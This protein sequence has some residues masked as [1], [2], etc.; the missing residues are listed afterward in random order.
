MCGV[1]Y[2]IAV[3]NAE[4]RGLRF[5]D[6]NNTSMEDGDVA[7]SASGSCHVCSEMVGRGARIDVGEI[8]CR[9]REEE[10]LFPR[11]LNFWPGPG[12]YLCF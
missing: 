2:G 9:Q 4:D 1:Q 12:G 7:G 5:K 11:L 10:G 3:T 8:L 6:G